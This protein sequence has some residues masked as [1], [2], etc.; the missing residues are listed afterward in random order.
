[1]A[2]QRSIFD[3]VGP[4]MIGPSSSHTAGA[5]RLGALARAV[6]GGTPQAAHIELHGSFASTGTGHGTD[7]ALVAGLLGLTPD[8]ARIVTAFELATHSG[9]TVTFAEADLGEVHPNSARL[10]LRAHDGHTMSVCGSSLGGGDVLIT[11]ID[12]FDVEIEGEMPLLVV[13]HEDRLG[14]IAA[15]TGILAESGVNI[16][17]MSV[18][19][20]RRGARA[21]MLIETD[22]EVDDATSDRIAALSGV[23]AV[24]SVPAI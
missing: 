8:D 10:M 21:L 3:V 7:L 13:E 20:E 24:R 11:A 18:S 23:S 5:V 9:L 19:R 22:A 12:G 16:A 17:R 4:I 15:V 6:F 2:R 14:E 1:M